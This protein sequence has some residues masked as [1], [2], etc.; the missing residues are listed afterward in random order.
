MT[1]IY[2]WYCALCRETPRGSGQGGY[3]G[4]DGISQEEERNAAVSHILQGNQEQDA[5]SVSANPSLCQ[6]LL[7]PKPHELAFEQWS[8]SQPI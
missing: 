8:P 6:L 3:S 7:G 5:V 2:N 1:L 4:R